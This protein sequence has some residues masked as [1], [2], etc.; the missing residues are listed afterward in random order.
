LRALGR[1]REAEADFKEAVRRDPGY[2]KREKEIRSRWRAFAAIF[3][4]IP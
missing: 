1:D 2:R 4:N 3:G